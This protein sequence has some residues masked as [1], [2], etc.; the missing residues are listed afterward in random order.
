MPTST[1][2]LF[3]ELAPVLAAIPQQP[4]TQVSTSEQLEVLVLVANRLGLYDAAR[5][6]ERRLPTY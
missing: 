1:N 5:N 6:L 3:A 4:Q 2:P